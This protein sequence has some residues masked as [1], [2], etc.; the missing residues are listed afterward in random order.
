MV[1]V[2]TFDT[3][4]GASDITT[5][6]IGSSTYALVAA[7]NDNGIQIINITD[8]SNPTVVSSITDGANGFD[9]L[10]G[11]RGIT[12]IQI[13]SFTYA[14]V[15][16]MDDD[17]VQI[18]NITDPAAPTVASSINDNTNGF[19]TLASATDITTVQIDTSIYALVTSNSED[20]VQII[21]IAESQRKLEPE[22]VP[23]PAT[24][25]NPL[26]VS[27]VINNTT[28]GSGGTFDELDGATNITTVKIDESTYALVI[29]FVFDSLQIIDITNPTMPIVVSSI[30]DG[31]DFDTLNGASDITTVKIGGSTYALITAAEDHGVQII[32][33]TDPTNPTGVSSRVDGE[34]DGAGGV[35]DE[36]R[37]ASGIATVPI[38]GSIYALIAAGLDDGIQIIDI[39]NPRNPTDVSSITNGQDDG[40]GTNSVFDELDGARGITI[41][42]IG[43]STYALV[44][45]FIDHGVQII[46]I[47]DPAT[48]TAVFSIND[49]DDDGTGT[50]SAFD[51]LRGADDITTVKI[52]VSTYALVASNLDDGV[53]IIDITNP[54]APTVASSINDDDTLEL[55]G[56]TAITP[57]TIGV[58]T[59]ALV[60]SDVDDGI[61]II[62][63]TNP[64][65]PTSASSLSD[66]STFA[67]LDGASG[68]TTVQIG[69][70]IY[71]LVASGTDDGI[72]IIRIAESQSEVLS[73]EL[74]LITVSLDF[75]TVDVDAIANEGF[76][77]IQNSGIVDNNVKIGA[78]FWCD[79]TNNG[80]TGFN[81]VMSPSQTSFDTSPNVPYAS[82][83]AFTDF[84]YDNTGKI[85][86]RG[87]PASPFMSPDLFTLTP[88]Q[89]DAVYL[90]TRAE[91]IPEDGGS[92]N[93][94][95]GDIS[96]EIIFETDCN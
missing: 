33:I 60:A 62:N 37:G 46:D 65:M 21:Q 2:V 27:S 75:G 58:S 94:F 48:P 61:Q 77:T 13:G 4:G 86:V 32:N 50:N 54:A 8:P 55:R 18:I 66:G 29:S 88:D 34:S 87:V 78:D 73:C 76:I 6:T 70:S 83:Q 71:A 17:G 64:T 42:T 28:D 39:T 5:I 41:A 69:A 80:C 91:L 25:A 93:R 10:G 51:E 84:I 23:K 40:T 49:G 74:T 47:S 20:A 3:L 22:P 56:A 12:T 92:P 43:V 9:T 82:K 7:Q 15:A 44:A 45:S 53:Q 85:P 14:L 16:A 26:A 89:T 68:I 19:T 1:M 67:T 36:Y 90:Q 59:Y 95:I 81:S 38:D 72:Q 31:P 52:G 11:A 30:S 79:T 24:P 57:I 63:I 96:Q 35:F